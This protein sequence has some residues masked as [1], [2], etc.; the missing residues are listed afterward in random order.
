M[1]WQRRTAAASESLTY[2]SAWATNAAAG[3]KAVVKVM[4][5]LKQ[6]PQ[7]LV[8]DL[9]GGTN[10]TNYGLSYLD[11]VPDGGWSDEYKT[12]KLVLRH[13]PAGSFVMGGRNTD[14]PGAV[15]TN[16]HMVTITRD[17]YMGVFEVTQRQWELVM[18]TRP[19]VFSNAACYAARPVERVSYQDIRGPAL[20]LT[21]PKTKDIDDDGFLGALRRRTG[22]GGLDL[23]TEAQWEYACRAE[24]TTS[25][26]SGKNISSMGSCPE[27]EEVA[28][29]AYN[30]G[31]VE[32]GRDLSETFT[33]NTT[34]V[35]TAKVGSYLP[36][37]WGLY[38]MHGNV[39]ELCVDKWIDGKHTEESVDPV[40][41]DGESEFRF[42]RG[43]SFAHPNSNATRLLAYGPEYAAG[44]RG[45][46]QESAV[47]SFDT[48]FR[49][50]LQGGDLPDF[51]AAATL[52]DEAG[53]GVS[54]WTPMRAGTYCLTHATMNSETNAQ[55]LSAWFEVPGPQLAIVPQGEL[56]NGVMVVIIGG[57]DGWT[58]R[59]TTDGSE[60]T[61][62]SPVY[63]SAFSL[64]SSGTV[65][66]VAYDANGLASEEA[67]S[68]FTL[69]DALSL[70][71]AVAR[72]RYPW[73]GKVDIDVIVGGNPAQT[74]LVSL[75]A[76]DLDGGA[77]LPLKTAWVV[78]GD[79]TN[80]VFSLAPGRYRFVWDADADIASDGDFPRV[81]VSV[82]AAD[83]A[84]ENLRIVGSQTVYSGVALEW[85]AADGA[86]G[87]NVYRTIGATTRKLAS[88][89][90]TEFTDPLAYGLDATYFVRAV[91]SGLEGQASNRVSAHGM[92]LDA[93]E[94]ALVYL[95]MD[96]EEVYVATDLNKTHKVRNY[97]TKFPYFHRLDTDAEWLWLAD[98]EGREPGSMY[99][100]GSA[101]NVLRFPGADEFVVSNTFS[102]AFWCRPE[103]GLGTIVDEKDSGNYGVI[104]ANYPY[105]LSATH[106]GDGGQAGVGIAVGT[107]GIVVVEHASGWL[108]ATLVYAAEIGTGWT[109]VAVTIEDNGAPILYVNG[110]KVRTGKKSVKV[111]NIVNARLAYGV[112]GN[113]KGCIDDFFVFDRA[114]S[115]DEVLN[116]YGLDTAGDAE[117]SE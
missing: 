56:T 108:P 34:D 39:S 93:P 50:C 46:G 54:T 48:G 38:D 59:Y 73:N 110:T 23:P 65:R 41:C 89:A 63:G 74:Y 58:I 66:V 25:L 95:P 90:A 21:W 107:N 5:V 104:S 3:A 28:R 29:Y 1:P 9:S 69:H 60:P 86:E 52:V 2:S 97:G 4:P 70:V 22:L 6:K 92:S 77:A 37:A 42:I 40:G 112:Y 33:A 91:I 96:G 101:D 99:A 11:D 61:A 49:V 43:G 15:N 20:G 111:K 16:L 10:A 14:Y 8:V 100:A 85:D 80:S 47:R 98:R 87:Y 71:S 83:G 57:E 26:N 18:G 36:N 81:A 19:S 55:L 68:T 94:G 105:V 109:H 53:E 76:K 32:N 115:A 103:W 44:Y 72:Q 116:V 117:A 7:Y 17:F 12:S 62:S 79:V 88:V 30:S 13:I 51:A 84:T 67:T 45:D 31:W 114:L 113:Y 106:G 35:G 78:G 27:V 24:T 75:T 102:V 64:P 82:S